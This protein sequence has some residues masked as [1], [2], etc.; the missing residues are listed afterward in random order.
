MYT[1]PEDTRSERYTKLQRAKSML[2]IWWVIAFSFADLGSGIL[3]F[4]VSD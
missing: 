2:A 4:I 1:D 3:T